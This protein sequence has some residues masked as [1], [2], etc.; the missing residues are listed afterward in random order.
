GLNTIYYTDFDDGALVFRPEIGFGLS[1]FKLV[2]GYNW[3]LT[4]K[5]FRGI[6]SN[7]VGL[8]YVLPFKRK[9]SF[10]E[11]KMMNKQNCFL[12]LSFFF[13]KHTESLSQHPTERH[14][15]VKCLI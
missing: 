3:N 8:T 2:Y 9:K 11:I 6:N 7:F 5:E 10:R 13:H 15:F 14:I 12:P 4:N 1:G